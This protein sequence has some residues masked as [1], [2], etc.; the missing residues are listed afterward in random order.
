MGWM[1]SKLLH[2]VRGHHRLL[3]PS[4]HHGQVVESLGETV[5]VHASPFGDTDQGE[6]VLPLGN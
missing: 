4:L 3:I 2:H 1:C 6:V 5:K